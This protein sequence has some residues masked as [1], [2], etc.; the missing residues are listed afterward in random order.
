[1]KIGFRALVAGKRRKLLYP[2]NFFERED[3]FEDSNGAVLC[4]VCGCCELKQIEPA[5]E[6]GSVCL[7]G[8][9]RIVRHA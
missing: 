6:S 8:C 2:D 1:M 9:T 3:G 7:G 5:W 4:P